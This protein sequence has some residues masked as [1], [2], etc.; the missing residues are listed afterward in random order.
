MHPFWSSA[1]PAKEPPG[2][3]FGSRVVQGWPEDRLKR[4]LLKIIRF[5]YCL[6]GPWQALGSSREPVGVLREAKD[7]LVPAYAHKGSIGIHGHGGKWT[8]MDATGRE[9]SQTRAGSP[10]KVYIKAKTHD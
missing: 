8:Q 2:R 7:A 5:S 1:G 4:S 10:V 9:L 6:G 3:Q